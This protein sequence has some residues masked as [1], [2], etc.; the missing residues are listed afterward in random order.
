M[1]VPVNPQVVNSEGK[2]LFNSGQTLYLIAYVCNIQEEIAEF[3]EYYGLPI[4]STV[5]EQQHSRV[6]EFKAP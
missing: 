5:D 2:Y 3:S 6:I 4:F 1:V